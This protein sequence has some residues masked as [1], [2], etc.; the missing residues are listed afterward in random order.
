MAACQ[1]DMDCPGSWWCNF[2]TGRC[3]KPCRT[4][5][6]CPMGE[7]CLNLTCQAGCRSDKECK[8]LGNPGEKTR[9]QTITGMYYCSES[10]SS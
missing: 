7:T 5:G 3:Q 4:T 2:E 1:Q 9:C 8:E 6:D 10:D